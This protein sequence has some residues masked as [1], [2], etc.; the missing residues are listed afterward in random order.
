MTKYLKLVR[1]HQWIKN[2]FIFIPLIFSGTIT[3]IFH[4]VNSI[5]IFFSFSLIASFVYIMN[6]IKDVQDDRKHPQKRYRPIASGEISVTRAYIIGFALLLCAFGLTYFINHQTYI[7]LGVY[8]L[9]NIVYTFYVKKIVIWDILFLASFYIMRILAGA[10][11]IEV[12]VTSWLILT[13]F[14]ATL[15]IGSGK[16]YVELT[17]YGNS[18]RKVLSQYSIEFLQYSLYLASFCTVLFYSM[19]TLQKSYY[20]QF[21][22]IFVVLGFLVYF[23]NLYRNK[24]HDDPVTTLFKSYDLL[25]IFCLWTIYIVIIT[26]LQY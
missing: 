26:I 2:L 3:D 12:P 13:A 11:A 21:S 7:V 17:N 4:I 20:H 1:V 19:Y 24:V 5:I 25:I 9:S 14:F 18:S 23:F 10:I 6:D 16:R 22:I 8:I 15:F